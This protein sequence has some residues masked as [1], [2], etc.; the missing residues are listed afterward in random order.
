MTAKELIK[1][2]LNAP[3]L[4]MEVKLYSL[5]DTEEVDFGVSQFEFIS[6]EIIEIDIQEDKGIIYIDSKI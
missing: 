4:E 2:L 5:I 1:E 3:D 6:D